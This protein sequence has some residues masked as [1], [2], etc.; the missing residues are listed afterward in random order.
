MGNESTDGDPDSKRQIELADVLAGRFAFSPFV[1]TGS[2]FVSKKCMSA[3]CAK[4]AVETV[5]AFVREFD[6]RAHIDAKKIEAFTS[7]G[8]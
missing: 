7:V 6:S 5:V 1:D 4:W 8:I 2:D 3:G